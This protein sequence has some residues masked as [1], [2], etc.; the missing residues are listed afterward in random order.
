MGIIN[1]ARFY[2]PSAVWGLS[3]LW[4]QAH[5]IQICAIDLGFC[6]LFLQA[7]FACKDKALRTL[8]FS[9]RFVSQILSSLNS[10]I[11]GKHTAST[12]WKWIGA[13]DIRVCHKGW[14]SLYAKYLKYLKYLKIKD[15]VVW[16]EGYEFLPSCFKLSSLSIPLF[17]LYWECVH[18]KL[19][20]CCETLNLGLP[21][22]DPEHGEFKLW[23]GTHSSVQCKSI[24]LSWLA[25]SSS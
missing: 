9:F 5:A 24:L 18:Q 21:W 2:F 7:G 25:A 20:A 23:K 10:G 8:G 14:I 12:P 13:W 3:L 17:C 6:S 19:F 1:K 15:Q 11:S 22:A 4:C 16:R